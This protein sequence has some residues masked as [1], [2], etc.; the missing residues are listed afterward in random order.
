MPVLTN[1]DSW[2][3]GGRIFDIETIDE[4]HRYHFISVGSEH[5]LSMIVPEH[6]ITTAM[7]YVN[8]K[9]ELCVMLERAG[10]RTAYAHIVS[11]RTNDDIAAVIA[12]VTAAAG[13]NPGVMLAL[14]DVMS[15]HT[16]EVYSGGERWIDFRVIEWWQKLAPT[17]SA[18]QA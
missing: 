11:A 5:R 9:Y 15:N 13:N 3:F 18:D 4:T 7:F 16:H 10:Y 8:I 2:H 6:L 1:S 14:G 17:A 12:A